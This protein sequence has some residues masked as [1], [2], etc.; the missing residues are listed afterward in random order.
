MLGLN[1]LSGI[2]NVTTGK[3]MMRIE[4]FAGEFYNESNTL[5]ADRNY[6]KALPEYLAEI[7]NRV[8]TSKLALWDEL[9]NVLQEYETDVREVNFDRKTW[10]SKMFGTSTLFFMNNA[11]EHWMQ[12]RTSLA[13]ADAYKMKAPNGKIV[14]LW[15][16]IVTGK[17]IGRAHV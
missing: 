4:S 14:S 1:L 13:L 11:G 17:Q 16:A 15:D 5:V 8:K 12:N 2:S 6:G 9:F 3:I 7:G 10:F